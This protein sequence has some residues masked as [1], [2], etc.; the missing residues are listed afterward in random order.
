MD[1]AFCIAL[2]GKNNQYCCLELPATYYQLQDAMDKLKM[3]PVKNR[4][5]NCSIREPSPFS[6]TIWA[7]TVTSTS[8]TPC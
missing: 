5:W 4:T 8:S 3:A 1:N 2:Y 6:M 7:Q